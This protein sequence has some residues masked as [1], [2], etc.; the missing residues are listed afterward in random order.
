MPTGPEAY[1]RVKELRVAGNHKIKD[2]WEGD[3]ALKV[4]TILDENEVN[5][6]S[7]DVVR[8]GYVNEPSGNVTLW[9]G[10]Y[11]NSLTYEVGINVAF[12]LKHVLSDHGI[13]DMDVEIRESVLSRSAGPKLLGPTDDLDPT[14]DVR[15]PFTPTL[16]IPIC[17]QST[18]TKEGSSGFFLNEGGDRNRLLLVTA[19]HVVFPLTENNCFEHRSNSQP[20]HKVLILSPITFRQHI[21][22]IQKLVKDQDIVINY[23]SRRIKHMEGKE[24]AAAIKLRADAQSKVEMATATATALDEFVNYLLTNWRTDDN[25]VLGHVIFS[26]PIALGVGPDGF[27]QDMAIIAVDASKFDLGSFPCNVIDLGFK[28]SPQTLTSMMHG[29]IKNLH[30]FDF[31]VDRLLR[32][33]GSI[34]VEEMRNPKMLDQNG[35]P[36]IM[37]LKRGPTTGLTVGCAN[38][39]ISYTRYYGVVT[40]VSKEWAILPFDRAPFSDKGDSGCVVVDGSGRIGG[41][42]TGGGSATDTTDD[43]TYV[44][45]FQFIMDT[46]HGYEHL[47]NA[48]LSA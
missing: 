13:T 12:Q 37:V 29:N 19:R 42:L 21:A 22:S 47:A 4:H 20:Y 26:P 3:V 1:Q 24:D 41:I 40:G 8:F 10:V 48:H 25:R 43:I 28:Y 30:S 14:A 32:L 18:P 2:I 11:P 23:N 17:A 33:Q 5:W 6:T 46:I 39:V 38:N 45:P 34:T 7:T 35:Q 44:T 15:E 36:C 9:I 27:T 16:G 31:P